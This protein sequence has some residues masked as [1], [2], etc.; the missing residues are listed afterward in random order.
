MVAI[1]RD[2]LSAPDRQDRGAEV[3]DLGARI[4]EVVLARDA[5]AARQRAPGTAGRRR[6]RR[7]RCRRQRP[8]RV[9]RHELDVDRPRSRPARPGPSP[10]GRRGSPRSSSRA[11][12]LA[13][14]MLRK[15]G[16]ATSA[17]AIGVAPGSSAVSRSSSARAPWRSPSAPSDTAG[18]ASSRGCWRSRRV[19]IGRPL[20]LDGGSDDAAGQRA[21]RRRR[22]PGPRR[23]RPPRE[24]DRGSAARGS[25]R[26][27]RSLVAWA[28][29]LPLGLGRWYRNVSLAHGMPRTLVA[30]G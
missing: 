28:R 20:D 25:R 26:H 22:P 18:R 16:G 7:A 6:M 4:V 30:L 10:P 5:L 29:V 19:G 11:P 2:R 8:G 23:D 15:P 24:P 1:L 12:R 3:A 9:R 17:V 14:R 13:S 21:A 27:G